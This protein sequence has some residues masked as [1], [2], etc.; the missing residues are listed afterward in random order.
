M[1]LTKETAKLIKPGDVVKIT[2]RNGSSDTGVVYGND[3]LGLKM[4]KEGHMFFGFGPTVI[5][6]GFL[7]FE[8]VKDHAPVKLYGM[9]Y[10]FVSNRTPCFA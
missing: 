8:F 1:K 2:Y 3:T 9:E 4:N 7:N 5:E 10:D 6:Q